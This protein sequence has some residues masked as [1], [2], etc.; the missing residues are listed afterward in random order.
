MFDIR[1]TDQ[2]KL[3]VKLRDEISSVHS[4]PMSLSRRAVLTAARSRPA[5]IVMKSR[6]ASSSHDHHDH[7]ED[8]TIYPPESEHTMAVAVLPS[9][10]VGYSL[11]EP[12]LGEGLI[13]H[14]LDWCCHQIRTRTERRCLPYTVDCNVQGP[15]RIMAWFKRK[16]HCSSIPGIR[17]QPVDRRCETTS[18]SSVQVPSVSYIYTNIGDGSHLIHRSLTQVS[19]FLNRVGET[20]DMRNVVAKTDKDVA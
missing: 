10:I 19:P 11:Y 8:A 20:V 3:L 13:F 2:Q 16:T 18:H 12:F 4:K 5:V 7:H 14:P 1:I 9:L 6:A 17:Q 15:T